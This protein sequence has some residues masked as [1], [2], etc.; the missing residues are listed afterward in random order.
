MASDVELSR[1]LNELTPAEIA[2]IL[3]LT[4]VEV[5]EI[6]QQPLPNLADGKSSSS[7][8]EHATDEESVL[9]MWAADVQVSTDAVL[10]QALQHSDDAAFIASHQYAQRLLAAEKRNALDAEFAWRLQELENKGGVIDDI[11]DIEQ[12][13]GIEEIE[14]I[15]A[16]NPNEKGKGA[17][18]PNHR[19][20]HDWV[21]LEVDD[22]FDAQVD[23]TQQ[24]PSIN[25]CGICM[26]AI[27]LVHSP[28]NAARYRQVSTST[29]RPFGVAIPCPG[30]HQYCQECL[31]FYI[32]LKIDPNGDGRG[33]PNTIVFPIVCPGCS[34]ADEGGGLTD[35]IASRIL[36]EKD[37]QIW[38]RQRLLDSR[39]RVYCPNKQ[40]SVLVQNHEDTVGPQV[41]CLACHHLMCIPCRSPWHDN[42]T[43]QQYQALPPDERAPED[44]QALQLM[45]AQDWRR[46]PECMII[47][48]LTIGCNHVTCR[49]GSQ[50]CFKCGSKWDAKMSKCTRNPP[51]ALWDEDMLL[52]AQARLHRNPPPGANLVRRRPPL[53]ILNERVV[54]YPLH[55]IRAA[56]PNPLPVWRAHFVWFAGWLMNIFRLRRGFNFARRPAP[57]A[58]P[59]HQPLLPGHADNLAHGDQNMN[60]NEDWMLEPYVYPPFAQIPLGLYL[61]GYYSL[62]AVLMFNVEWLVKLS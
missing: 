22:D 59:A 58:H 50:F 31:V 54:P 53:A 48:E 8:D 51:C 61:L 28:V 47:V 15:L 18:K 55:I 24:K 23:S 16:S 6:L 32:K 1:L 25:E 7:L 13:L 14:S 29:T 41:E 49:C 17:I 3:E 12:V 34:I 39:P 60:P 35:E 38:R 19:E 5:D 30:D 43:C 42:L 2:E 44:Q 57:V 9:A 46:C 26:E 20:A 45:Q 62:I 40:C 33:N 52:E 10:A 21:Q 37:F 4:S 11:Y 56:I 36:S 27:Q